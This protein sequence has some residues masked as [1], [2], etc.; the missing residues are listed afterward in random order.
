LYKDYFIFNLL[1]EI[2]FEILYACNKNVVK[3]FN[4]FYIL[5]IDTE[6][7]INYEVSSLTKYVFFK[8]KKKKKKK[9]NSIPFIYIIM[10]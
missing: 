7:Y 2:I 9:K 10:N 6:K 5:Y 4:S 1:I 8:K 3:I